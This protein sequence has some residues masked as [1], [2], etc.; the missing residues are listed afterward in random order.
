[1]IAVP[2]KARGARTTRKQECKDVLV[3]LLNVAGGAGQDKVVPPVV[4]GLSAAWCD[5]VESDG[6][7]ADFSLA[8][9]ANGAVPVE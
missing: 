5:V 7:N 8:V 3:R 9:G 4:G 6:P 2:K 1:M